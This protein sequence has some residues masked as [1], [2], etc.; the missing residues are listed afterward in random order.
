MVLAANADDDGITAYHS[1]AWATFSNPCWTVADST[2]SGGDIEK[3][4]IPGKDASATDGSF[5]VSTSCPDSGDYE[6]VFTVTLDSTYSVCKQTHAHSLEIK[7]NT[8]GDPTAFGTYLSS[9]TTNTAGTVDA[10][11]SWVVAADASTAT[12]E[13]PKCK[14]DITLANV[15]ALSSTATTNAWTLRFEDKKSMTCHLGTAVAYVPGA[16]VITVTGS[17]TSGGTVST[18][19]TGSYLSGS[20]LK[21]DYCT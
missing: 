8:S 17:S 2:T 6:Y 16:V 14:G 13:N 12:T 21:V 9:A 10:A 5:A 4:F 1:T 15:S 11:N 3:V 19:V 7:R 18:T 20:Q